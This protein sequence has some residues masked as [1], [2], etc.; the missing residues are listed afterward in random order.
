MVIR[1]I[2]EHVADH[3]WFAVAVDVGIVV[4]GV[5][6]GTQVSNWNQDRQDR[7]QGHDYRLR[8]ID[9]LDA[10]A[11][12]MRDRRAYYS[13]VRDHARSALAALTTPGKSTDAR[14]LIDAYEASQITPRRT[15]RFTYDEMLARGALQWVGD[16]ALREQISNYYIGV[17]TGGVT[18]N[19][20][21]PYREHIREIM[22]AAAQDAVRRDCPEDVYFTNSGAG[23]ARLAKNCTTLRLD[24]A[25]AAAAAATLR[26]EP[27]L[28][29]DLTRLIA[30]H[31]VKIGLVDAMTGHRARVRALILAAADK[32]D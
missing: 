13:D 1:R 23:Q 20:I 3:N 27:G 8:L 2:R 4:V 30:D 16:A 24:P 15:K 6:L 7:Q 18:F 32:G 21:P 11:E 17:D 31:E 14:F 19:S 12:D 28:Q 10:N 25:I 29:K 26:A 5:F 9:D 22:R